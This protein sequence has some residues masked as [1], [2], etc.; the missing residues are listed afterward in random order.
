MDNHKRR[1]W[2]LLAVA[3]PLLVAILAIA[4]DN[5][6]DAGD[7]VITGHTESADTAEPAV[8]LTPVAPGEV[9]T[10]VSSHSERAS[11][12]LATVVQQADTG[13]EALAEEPRT[14]AVASIGQ[15]SKSPTTIATPEAED[16]V[17]ICVFEDGTIASPMRAS[18]CPGLFTHDL[19]EANAVSAERRAGTTTATTTT[20]AA[21]TTSST[22]PPDVGSTTTSAPSTTTTEPVTTTTTET[23]DTTVVGT[24]PPTTSTPPDTIAP[25]DS[26]TTTTTTE[27]KGRGRKPRP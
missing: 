20:T 2:Y 26:T 3:V 1:G 23:S 6:A 7:V 4:K 16:E 18:V 21:P 19:A 9:V 15:T 11:E 22:Q 17:G 25:P 5:H 24:T 27:K 13:S 8:E 10:V 14:F 12:E